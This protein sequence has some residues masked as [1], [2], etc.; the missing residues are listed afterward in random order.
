M[1]PLIR[2]DALLAISALC[3]SGCAAV[4]QQAAQE[5]TARD[6]VYREPLAEVWPEALALLKDKGFSVKT[7][8]AEGHSAET[9]WLLI[10]TP[11]S[12]GTTYA[13]Y[14]VSGVERGPSQSTVHF[15]RDERT[16]TRAADGRTQHQDIGIQGA[17]LYPTTRDTALEAE[18]RQRVEPGAVALR[19]DH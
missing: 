13:R 3:F 8:D 9:E 14:S 10:G 18:L 1:K 5:D 15:M 7:L 16:Q 17:G 6:H 4:R 12:L 19:S 2:T 11:T